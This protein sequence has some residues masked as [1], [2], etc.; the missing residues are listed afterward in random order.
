MNFLEKIKQDV[1]RSERIALLKEKHGRELEDVSQVE[2]VVGV[3][4]SPDLMEVGYDYYYD[5]KLGWYRI[6][7]IMT[8]GSIDYNRVE[9]EESLVVYRDYDI[10]L[11]GLSKK[12]TRRLKN[13]RLCLSQLTDQYFRPYFINEMG[14]KIF[15]LSY[16]EFLLYDSKHNIKF[17]MKSEVYLP[18]LGGHSYFLSEIDLDDVDD[19][20]YKYKIDVL[21]LFTMGATISFPSYLIDFRSRSIINLSCKRDYYEVLRSIATGQP[22]TVVEKYVGD[23]SAWNIITIGVLIRNKSSLYFPTFKESVQQYNDAYVYE[24]PDYA[25]EYLIPYRGP[26]EKASTFTYAYRGKARTVTVIDSDMFFSVKEGLCLSDGVDLWDFHTII[27]YYSRHFNTNDV[28]SF[29]SFLTFFVRH[30]FSSCCCSFHEDISVIVCHVHTEKP[31]V[32]EVTRFLVSLSRVHLDSNRLLDSFMG[33]CAPVRTS[34]LY[35]QE[36]NIDLLTSQA[37]VFATTMLEHM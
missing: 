15:V 27:A 25:Y 9:N 16:S 4:D 6:K 8:K 31:N 19:E 26:I 13:F 36:G 22:I 29:V 28:F 37:R 2:I 5:K 11:E 7:P 1:A 32:D 3:I 12:K 21:E 24:D 14:V 20:E 34:F 17:P 23:T 10:A 33:T 30:F 35:Y 18:L